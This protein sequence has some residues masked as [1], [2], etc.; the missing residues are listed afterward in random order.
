MFSGR[1]CLGG[2]KEYEETFAAQWGTKGGGSRGEVY[3]T[4]PD[5]QDET[6]KHL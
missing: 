4:L 3:L 5:E 2:S 1:E 6:E